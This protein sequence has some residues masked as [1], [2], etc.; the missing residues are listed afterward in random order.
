MMGGGGMGKKYPL[1]H[2]GCNQKPLRGMGLEI[3]SADGQACSRLNTLQMI[4]TIPMFDED[5]FV[6]YAR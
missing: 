3:L 6:E 5:N 1:L 2:G 4:K